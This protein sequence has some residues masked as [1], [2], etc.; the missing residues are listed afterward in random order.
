MILTKYTVRK[1]KKMVKEIDFAGAM[2]RVKEG[3]TKV[4]MLVPI[5]GETSLSELMQASGFVLTVQQKEPEKTPA[6]E[7]QKKKP[8][9]H[10]KIIAL[11]EAGWSM[12]KIAAE[13]GCSVQTVLNHVNAEKEKGHATD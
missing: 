12:S 3:S 5:T 8:I 11:K 13:V 1:E 7:K 6:P 4:C 9:D 10:G 2:A